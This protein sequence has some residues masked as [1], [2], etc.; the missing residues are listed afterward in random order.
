MQ[1]TIAH[2]PPRYSFHARGNLFI[3]GARTHVE[4][5]EMHGYDYHIATVVGGVMRFCARVLSKWCLC[6]RKWADPL[7]VDG[8]GTGSHSSRLFEVLTLDAEVSPPNRKLQ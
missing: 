8:E 1:V 5:A 6:R 3:E 4:Y 7:I 2:K